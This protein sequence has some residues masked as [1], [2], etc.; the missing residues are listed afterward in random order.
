MDFLNLVILF[1]ISAVIIVPIST[2]FQLGSVLGYLIAGIIIGPFGLG[3][4][5]NAS[6]VYH[7][8]ELGVI[9]LMFIIGLELQPSRLW[10]LRRSVFGLGVAQ[11]L[12]T[13]FLVFLV[14]KLLNQDW[15]AAFVIG[16]ALSLSSTALVL[17]SL[18]ERNQLASQHGRD[19]FAVLLFQDIAVIPALALLPV[20]AP[21][22]DGSGFDWLR[23]ASQGLAVLL[24]VVG[25]R[26]LLKPSFQMIARVENRDL[27][28]AATLLIVIGSAVA[29]ASV[30]L[31]MG[32]GAFAAGVLL[33]DSEFR[34]E[35]E[36]N[37]DPFKGLLLGLFFISVGMS[38]QINLI[39]QKP[40]LVLS[41]VLSLYLL[42]GLTI[43]FLKSKL[44]AH[45]SSSRKLAIYLSQGGE[46]AFVIFAAAVSFKVLDQQIAG[47]LVLVVT[48]S[49]LLAPLLFAAEEKFFSPRM[50]P[51]EEPQYDQDFDESP[52]VI[53][54]FGRFGQVVAR[55]L[56]L[57]RIR[58]TAL[59]K[60][61][62]HVDFV[63]KYGNR[64]FY[65]DAARLDVLNA[66]K[67]GSAR[68]FVLA[69]DDVDSSLKTAALVKR[70]FP[71]VM[72]FARARNRFHS[73]KLLD[74]GITVFYRET[75]YSGL[76]I[77]RH[78]LEFFGLQKSEAEMVIRRFKAYDEDL[79][80]RQ[81]AVYQNE[82]QLIQTTTQALADLENLF[83]SDLK[84]AGM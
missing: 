46:F 56:S 5:E 11:V 15:Q 26:V 40:V 36:A 50:D 7:F 76:E 28:T 59:D 51:Q 80:L 71:H 47:L 54:G 30:G 22:M 27:F 57:K 53:A 75:W 72:V 8:S 48:L 77:G 65:G 64:I 23:L 70:H 60:N 34:H 9:F 3:F 52:V 66:A 19:A 49:M 10:I 55:L 61:A 68:L 16:T 24:F 29:M 17:Q 38:A 79:L 42:K 4:I 25:G 2:K 81:H 67:V 43:Y 73:Y 31:S 18:K 83:E 14:A 33:S 13:S 69:I 74:L 78:V 84:E 41:L 35:L 21:N 1:L 44:R 37:I 62:A 6:S 58:F 20:L 82:A 32:F 12:L 39:G 45:H 63:R